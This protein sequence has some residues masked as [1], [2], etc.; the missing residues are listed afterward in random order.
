MIVF[1]DHQ[2][3]IRLLLPVFNLVEC[4][5]WRQFCLCLNHEFVILAFP[6]IYH[7]YGLELRIECQDQGH[8]L[9]E[10]LK[11]SLSSLPSPII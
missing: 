1:G 10:V 3:V 4:N 2:I 7:C 6:L 9:I 11:S 5:L 8:A